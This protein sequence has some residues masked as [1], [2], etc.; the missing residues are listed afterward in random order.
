VIASG[1]HLLRAAAVAIALAGAL[2]PAITSTRRTKPIV[3]VIAADAIADSAARDG[4]AHALSRRFAVIPAPLVTADAT[5]LVGNDVP[6]ES[7]QIGRPAF[8]IAADRRG[9][10][11][12]VEAVHA[13]SVA[14]LDS[15]VPVSAVVH[16]TGARDRALNVTLTANGVA[17]DRV[18]HTVSGDEER[19]PVILRYAP[20]AAGAAQLRVIATVTG[21]AGTHAADV[22]VDVRAVRWSVLFYDPR[23]SWIST[24]VRRAV[25][26]DRRFVVTSR[27][28][29]S[30]NVG[31]E[32]GRPP[33]RLDDLGGLARFD[34]VIV[35]A[36]HTLGAAEVSGLEAFMR[37]RG[38]SVV[39]L[40]DDRAS[41]P[42][43]R[44]AGVTRWLEQNDGRVVS[45]RA[46]GDSSG[47]R[48]GDVIWPAELPAGAEVIAG[49][50]RPVIWRSP[51]G[52]GQLVV[53]GAVD[54]WRYRDKSLSA[55]DEFWK[56]LIAESANIAPAA[57]SVALSRAVLTPSEDATVT[58]HVRSAELHPPF[59]NVANV[60]N[61]RLVHTSVTAV[62]EPA[63]EGTRPNEMLRVWP[64]GSVG[65]LEGRVRA[66]RA[67]GVYRLVVTA[68]GNRAEVPLVVV[69]KPVMRPVPDRSELAAAWASAHGGRV[70]TTSQ[71]AQLPAVLDAALRPVSRVETWHPMR[72][73][74]WLIPFA[75]LLGGEW[76]LRRRR[77]LA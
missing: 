10:A 18:S 4:A 33:N 30:R 58:V 47:L 13:P 74:L 36:P 62:L 20:A 56:T 40:M 42:Y 57:V 70:L 43:E 3:A 60:A 48:A 2:D 8:V 29:T 31:I 64:S 38:G 65:S 46:G 66:P 55:F 69:G 32:A 12:T 61:S 53:S 1:R 7:D 68:D 24:F 28:V 11:A 44:L 25:E 39:F 26:R 35:G 52:A 63:V 51:V 17:V 75:L 23:P 67:P 34:A 15:R 6:A 22:L 45:V 54:A 59:M 14:S 41:G 21:A 5:V 71:I 16:V 50:S 77:G 72:S 19:I 73:P 27:V 37:Q 9:P 49:A 76:W